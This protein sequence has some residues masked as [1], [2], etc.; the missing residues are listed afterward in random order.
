MGQAHWYLSTCITQL[1]NFDITI[2]Q[3]RYFMSILK[4]YLETAGCPNNTR[5]HR[6]P[7]ALDFTP[8][9]DDNF[10]TE[11]ETKTLSMEC[12]IDFAS[13]VGS[14]IYLALTRT[15]ITYAV[16]KLTKF[17]RNPGKKHFEAQIHLLRYLRDNPNLGVTFYSDKKRSPIYHSLMENNIIP[18]G[19]LF[20]FSDLSWNDDVD[21]GRS[22]GCY[23]IINMGGVVDHSSNLPDPVA[24]SSAEAEYNKPCLCGMAVTHLKMLLNDMEARSDNEDTVSIKLDSE[25]AIAIGNSFKDTKHTHHIFRRY[26]YVRDGIEAKRFELIW[27]NTENQFADIGTKQTPGP[28]HEFLMNKVLTKIGLV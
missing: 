20:A 3:T 24:L 28:R 8:S 15:D 7:F 4:R 22:T 6:T 17:T 21:T 12:N 18:R 9:A 16:N 2:D 5:C 11:E 26:H 23:P 1:A 13:C 10:T 14:L 19:P 25:S 27:I